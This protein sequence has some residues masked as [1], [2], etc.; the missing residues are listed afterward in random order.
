[1]YGIEAIRGDVLPRGRSV[2]G[3]LRPRLEDILSSQISCALHITG[4]CYGRRSP[5]ARV[6]LFLFQGWRSRRGSRTDKAR[7]TLLSSPLCCLIGYT[8]K[9]VCCKISVLIVE[10]SFSVKQLRVVRGQ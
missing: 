1:M 2:D 9:P 4:H 10:A 3:A 5:L 7:Y 6:A 8:R